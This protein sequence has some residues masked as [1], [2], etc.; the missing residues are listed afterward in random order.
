MKE[1][2]LKLLNENG[3]VYLSGEQVS[4]I[5]GISRTAVWKHIK[6]LKAAGYEIESI[7][8]KGYRL[9]SASSDLD[10]LALKM[11]IN[12]TNVVK[13]GYYFEQIDSTNQEAKRHALSGQRVNQLFV[14]DEQTAGRGR[15]GRT[16]ASQRKE[17]LWFSLLLYPEIQPEQASTLTLVAASAMSKAIEK[18]TGLDVGIKWPNDLI[19]GRKKVCGILTEMSAE[20]NH[21]HYV[22]VGIGTNLGQMTFDDALKDKATSIRAE[23]K[24][25]TAK[26]L[27]EAFLETFEQ[28]YNRFCQQ[29]ISGVIEEQKKRS[30]TIGRRVCITRGNEQ[31]EAEAIDIDN[32]GKLVVRFDDG[33]VT[34]LFSG[35]ISVRGINGYV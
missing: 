13:A 30:V 21:L 12:Q 16:W 25:I 29:D 24:S 15:L 27:L 20:I 14:A 35:E 28:D 10:A 3:A 2:I 9:K 33:S 26:A 7:S 22:I 11:M 34:A 31:L 18:T 17:G 1:K 6:A 19:L 5:L 23:G 32:E 4:Q 8:N